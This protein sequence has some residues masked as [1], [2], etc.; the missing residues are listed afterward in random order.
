MWDLHLCSEVHKMCIYYS[1][2]EEVPYY[3]YY[4][5]Y[6]TIQQVATYNVML[7]KLKSWG[8]EKFITKIIQVINE[9]EDELIW[10]T[11]ISI[12]VVWSLVN[13]VPF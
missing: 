9:E 3:L 13:N 10:Y 6:K 2:L 8:A 11:L 5:K 7:F 12:V 1:R 4:F